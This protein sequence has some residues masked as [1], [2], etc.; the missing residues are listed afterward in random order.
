[1]ADGTMIATGERGGLG[2][3]VEANEV[4]VAVVA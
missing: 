3:P 4:A 2:V 1:M